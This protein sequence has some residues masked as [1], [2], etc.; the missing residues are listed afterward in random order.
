[1]TARG[2]KVPIRGCVFTFDF[3]GHAHEGQPEVGVEARFAF[4]AVLRELEHRGGCLEATVDEHR[5]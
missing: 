1:M 4:A 5:V 2:R 3:V